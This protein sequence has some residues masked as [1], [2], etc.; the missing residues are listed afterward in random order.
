M[1]LIG[2]FVISIILNVMYI[3]SLNDRF[4]KRINSDDSNNKICDNIFLEKIYSVLFE[5]I[6]FLFEII[7]FLF[8]IINFDY[9]D[10][11]YSKFVIRYKCDENKKQEKTN[12]KEETILKRYIKYKNN[13]NLISSFILFII[14]II[15]LII[16]EAAFLSC[17]IKPNLILEP[18]YIFLFIRFIS[19]ALEIIIAFGKDVIEN[20]NSSGLNQGERFKLAV[21]SLCEIIIRSATIY[22]LLTILIDGKIENVL[23]D[24]ASNMYMSIINSINFASMYSSEYKSV[25]YNDPKYVYEVIGKSVI[26]LQGVTS[27]V[28]IILSFAQYLNPENEE[29]NKND[30]NNR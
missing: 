10:S 8:G 22:L 5:I 14:L 25:S 18:L 26:F 17:D 11:G 7:K 24:A 23:F 3:A 30:T 6:K 15:S 4:L 21:K 12:K 16:Y 13:C 29:E 27:F 28:L 1:Q 9:E 20:K 2:L 19:R